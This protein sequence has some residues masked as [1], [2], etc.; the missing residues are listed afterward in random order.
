MLDD[1]DWHYIAVEVRFLLSRVDQDMTQ[2][3]P[4]IGFVSLGCPKATVDSEQV[5]TQLRAEEIGRAH[6]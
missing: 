4:R 2:K 3:S 1:L 5:I 6:V